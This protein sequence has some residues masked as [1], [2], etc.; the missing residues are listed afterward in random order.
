MRMP[1]SSAS[2][3][4]S[5]FEALLKLIWSTYLSLAPFGEIST[6]PAPA[7]CCLFDPSKN[8]FHE[9]ERSRGPSVWT[10]I[11]STTKSGRTCALIDVGCLKHRLQG[12]NSMF[13]WATHPVAPGLLSMSEST[14]LLT[15]VIG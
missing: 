1:W 4:A 2:Y 13:H 14:A 7:P 6:T 5:L 9:L 12:L 3:S 11:H 15:T 8:I 10:S